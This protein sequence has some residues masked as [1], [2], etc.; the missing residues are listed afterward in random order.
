MREYRPSDLD[1]V[2]S[3]FHRSVHEI[4]SRDYS[5][6]QLYAWAPAFLDR[7]A[8]AR[9]MET[10]GVFVYERNDEIVGF[11]RIDAT[12]CVDLL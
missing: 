10:G 11:A 8:W 9:R 7:E 4:A 5:P 1:A 12:G 2:V 6:R 3:L